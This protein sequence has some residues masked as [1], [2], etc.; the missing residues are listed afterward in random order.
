VSSIIAKLY[1][2]VN[3]DTFWPFEILNS[4]LSSLPQRGYPGAEKGGEAEN[5]TGET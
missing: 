4:Y 1:S 3:Q 2:F 5:I